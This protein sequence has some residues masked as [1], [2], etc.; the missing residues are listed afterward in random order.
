MFIESRKCRKYSQYYSVQQVFVACRRLQ[1]KRRNHKSEPIDDKVFPCHTKYFVNT[2]WIHWE[3]SFLDF[4]CFSA[5]I[6]HCQIKNNDKITAQNIAKLFNFFFKK[7]GGYFNNTKRF[8]FQPVWN[9]KKQ[10]K[11]QQQRITKFK[12]YIKKRAFAFGA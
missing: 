6:C 9:T 2:F 1:R 4:S 5:L 12:T 3:F 8:S 10:Q 11:K 7:R